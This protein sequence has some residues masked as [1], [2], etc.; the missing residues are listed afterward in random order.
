MA[1]SDHG[2]CPP[3]VEYPAAVQER[4]AAEIE[5]LP[6]DSAVAGMM[7]DYQVL[8]RQARTCGTAETDRRG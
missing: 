1:G 4:A 8:R 6:W 2:A 5:A 7:A 3:V